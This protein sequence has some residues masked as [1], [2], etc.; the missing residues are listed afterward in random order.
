MQTA[1]DIFDCM[2]NVTDQVAYILVVYRSSHANKDFTYL[3]TKSTHLSIEINK[4]AV[5]SQR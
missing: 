2:T 5:L 3:L 1:I 4:K